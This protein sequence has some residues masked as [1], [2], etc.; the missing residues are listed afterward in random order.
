MNRNAPRA[1]GIG[2]ADA[3]SAPGLPA[4]GAA[5]ETLNLLSSSWP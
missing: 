1:L 3:L 5:N 2:F 4:G